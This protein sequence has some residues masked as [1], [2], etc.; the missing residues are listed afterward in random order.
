MILSLVSLLVL[1]SASFASQG[2]V[3]ARSAACTYHAA[4]D[5]ARVTIPGGR[6]R[7]RIAVVGAGSIR[8]I[9]K[10]PADCGDA[11][12]SNTRRVVVRGG[13]EGF[14]RFLIDNGGSRP[15]PATVSFDI[16]LGGFQGDLVIA[17]GSGHRDE[18]EGTDQ[19]RAVELDLDGVRVS[20]RSVLT[21]YLAM[22][23]GDDHA[24]ADGLS[25]RG[26]AGDDVLSGG[27]ASGG[28]GRDRLV[29]TSDDDFLEGGGGADTLLGRGGNDSFDGGSGGDEMRGGAGSD[30]TG[31]GTETRPVRVDVPMS[32]ASIGTATDSITS[33]ERFNLTDGDDIFVGGGGAELVTGMSGEDLIDGGGGDDEILSEG[34]PDTVVG[35]DGNDI[36][37]GGNRDDEI[38][39]GPGDDELYGGRSDDVL[40]GGP[41]DD[42]ANGGSG[43]NVCDAELESLSCD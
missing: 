27:G 42:Y 10:H 25:L 15:F 35:G 11:D 39:G 17:I 33:I 23:G 21:A 37:N 20:A 4:T 38:D 5:T 40:I 14:E 8:L 29:G 36:L 26:G 32:E 43:V 1:T 19:G 6:P 9:G 24:S 30:S 2:P 41:G 13:D 28:S 16:F 31:W 18:Y 22:R 3:D 34:G 12:V 7:T